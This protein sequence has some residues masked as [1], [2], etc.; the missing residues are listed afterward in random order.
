MIPVIT[1][2]DLPGTVAGFIDGKLLASMLDAAN[3][4]A[5]RLAPC[6]GG[7]TLEAGA[8]GVG[9]TFTAGT[10]RWVVTAVGAWGESVASNDVTVAVA[11][12]ATQQIVWS[13]KVDALS[14]RVYRAAGA[15][16]SFGVASL[17]AEISTA[18][19]F[20]YLDTGAAGSTGTPPA[21]D[22][23]SEARLIL[24]G[25]ISRWQK[26]WSCAPQQ[27]PDQPTSQPGFLLWPS[28]IKQLAELCGKGDQKAFTVDTAPD[29]Y[30]SDCP[31]WWG[32]EVGNHR[33]PDLR[34]P[35]SPYATYPFAG[36][37]AYCP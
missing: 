26:A 16:G 32:Y 25:A 33:G 9:G 35:P 20:E 21:T 19:V 12:G 17:V 13:P 27:N 23:V 18:G 31:D 1:S 24:I 22:R 7:V 8:A 11:A 28:E 10:Y 30:G 37:G 2:D 6:L 5:V 29:V 3:A 36:D 4:R 15:S 14:Y 34:F